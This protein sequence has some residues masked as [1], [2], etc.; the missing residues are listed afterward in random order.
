[1]VDTIT[2]FAYLATGLGVMRYAYI[3]LR[4]HEIQ[5]NA[6]DYP[7]SA[8][9]FDTEARLFNGFCAVFIG[10][11]WPL[12]ALILVITHNPP[13]STMELRREAQERDDYI[14]KLERELG[15]GDH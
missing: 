7:L 15:L 11:L 4:A 9:K 13:K 3:K 10:A 12:G 2:F 8:P 1:M 6:A 5:K 14:R